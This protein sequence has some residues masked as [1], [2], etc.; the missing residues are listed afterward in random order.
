MKHVVTLLVAAI[1]LTA[2]GGSNQDKLSGDAVDEGAAEYSDAAL[3][4]TIA[5]DSEAANA[6]EPPLPPEG[7]PP[8]EPAPEPAPAT[9]ADPLAPA[10]VTA[11]AGPSFD[12][13]NAWR[14]VERDICNDPDLAALDRTMASHYFRALKVADSARATLLQQSGAAFI[15]NRNRCPDPDCIAQAYRWRITEIADI[16]GRS[17]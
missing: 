15:R 1:L 13:S 7:S 12:C 17:R 10:P 5:A 2:C 11:A 8:T 16:M 9:E 4:G 6:A 3:N 14:D